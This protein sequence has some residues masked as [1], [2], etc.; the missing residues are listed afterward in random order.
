MLRAVDI[1]YYQGDMDWDLLSKAGIQ[2]VIMRASDGYIEDPKYRRNVQT[3][4]AAEAPPFLK[5][6]YHNFR[7]SLDIETQL[8]FFLARIENVIWDYPPGLDLEPGQK[9]AS[10]VDR[11]SQALEYLERGCGGAVLY[12]N[13]S[14]LVSL[15]LPPSFTR[16][17]LWLAH[18]GVMVPSVPLPW[19]PGQ[20]FAHQFAVVPGKL[21][22]T[23]PTSPGRP[24]PK[25]D[26]DVVYM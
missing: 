13:V 4:S 21:Y 26:L 25:I 11:L 8:A 10:L 16:W 3:L 14:K 7:V 18:W 22:G 20:L 17:K 6:A 9:H 1:S 23:R 19:F 24:Y 2:V 5:M 12:S 15:A